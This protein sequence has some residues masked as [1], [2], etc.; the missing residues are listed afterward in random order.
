MQ[1]INEAL[2]EE[3]YKRVLVYLDDILI[4][5][6]TMTEHMKLVCV[7]LKK[8]CTAQ[9]YAKRSKCKFHKDKIDYLVIIYPIRAYKCTLK[10]CELSLTGFHFRHGSSF[11]VS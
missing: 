5:T 10:W 11:K 6:E 9:L 1:L 8:V 2:H 3:L 7:M 4:Y